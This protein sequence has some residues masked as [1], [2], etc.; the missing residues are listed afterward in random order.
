MVKNMK[1]VEKECYVPARTY[2]DKKYVASDGKEFIFESDCLKHE[3]RLEIESHPIYTSAIRHVWLFEEGYGATLYYLSNQEDYEFFIET[4]GFDK[5][6][7]FHSDF[8]KYG[9]GWYLYWYEDGGDYPDDHYLKNYDAYE[10]QM[11]SDWE[12]YKA[13]MRSKMDA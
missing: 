10:K 2:I 9:A 12:E 5:K 3:K 8:D 11:D 1:V 13:D 7:Y 6:Y 4:Q